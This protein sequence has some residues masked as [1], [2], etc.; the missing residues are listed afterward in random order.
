[1][2]SSTTANLGR[3][4]KPK[5]D[6]T[7]FC[8]AMTEQRRPDG[9]NGNESAPQKLVH[10]VG[11]RDPNARNAPW[12]RPRPTPKNPDTERAMFVIE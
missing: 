12:V 5:A 11:Y 3:V 4:A 7:Q 9:R 1:M 8:G 2:G 10:L 6:A